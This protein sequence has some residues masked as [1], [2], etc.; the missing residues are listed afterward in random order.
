[1]RTQNA[2]EQGL[3]H[4][5]RTAEIVGVYVPSLSESWIAVASVDEISRTASRCI[6]RIARLT[7]E[8]RLDLTEPL[9]EHRIALETADPA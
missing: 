1:M 3:D 7:L 9:G 4:C 8:L 2:R 6:L 5:R